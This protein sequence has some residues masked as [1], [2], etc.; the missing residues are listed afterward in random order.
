LTLERRQAGQG[1]RDETA[2][3]APIAHGLGVRIRCVRTTTTVGDWVASRG[4]D[5]AV[6][7]RP[8]RARSLTWVVLVLAT[9]PAGGC[10]FILARRPPP[11]YAVTPT[12]ECTKSVAPAVVDATLATMYAAL[13]AGNELARAR[14]DDGAWFVGSPGFSILLGLQ[15]VVYG[16]SA[17]WGFIAAGECREALQHSVELD[18]GGLSP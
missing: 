9:L 15:A 10:S 18:P 13:T 17:Y 11:H 16:S 3:G 7:A 4:A 5:V 14:R 6:P 2:S 8:G 12:F 1:S